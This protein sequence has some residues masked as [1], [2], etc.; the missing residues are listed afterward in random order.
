MC[1]NIR[2]D[3]VKFF[4]EKLNTPLTMDKGYGNQSVL[5]R[6]VTRGPSRGVPPQHSKDLLNI[7]IKFVNL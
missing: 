3:G 6:A 5:V 2:C 4:W 7:H 1:P